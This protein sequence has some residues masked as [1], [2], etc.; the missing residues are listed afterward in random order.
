LI[1]WSILGANDY[2]MAL[3]MVGKIDPRLTRMPDSNY[4]RSLLAWQDRCQARIGC[5]VGYLENL[6]LHYWHGDRKNR[7]F[8]ARWQILVDHQFDPAIDLRTND[9]GLLEL[10]D[11]KPGLRDAIRA[12]FIA[13][14]EDAT[15]HSPVNTPTASAT[16]IR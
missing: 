3:G 16:K 11:V 9:E 2:Y 15:K 6:L 10:T 1:D 8:G 5:D 7:D 13:R 12:Y 14:Q 4:A